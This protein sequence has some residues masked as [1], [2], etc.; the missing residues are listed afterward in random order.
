MAPP[1][2]TY[3]IYDTYTNTFVNT[4]AL[5]GVSF[6]NKING[7]GS[8]SASLS[9]S[10]PVYT[11]GEI[12]W[13]GSTEPNGNRSLF[14]DRDGVLVWA[15]TIFGRDYDS[16]SQSLSLSG[17]TFDWYKDT[18]IQKKPLNYASQDT[19]TLAR[20]VWFRLEDRANPI[21]FTYLT[22]L[23]GVDSA[24]TSAD[25]QWWV[26]TGSHIDLLTSRDPGGIEY[27]IDTY[28]DNSVSPQVPRKLFY[29]DYLKINPVDLGLTA[30]LNSAG[31]N[32]MSYNRS[33]D[34][35]K[36]CTDLYALGAGSDSAQA[37]GYAADASRLALG[38]PG[39]TITYSAGETSSPSSLDSIA[40]KQ[41]K[42]NNTQL[43]VISMTVKPDASFNVADIKP[44][45]KVTVQITDPRHP[46]GYS[47]TF[48]IAEYTVTPGDNGEESVAL[49][50]EQLYAG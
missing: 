40:K 2:Y 20:A 49:T 33:E 37:W 11:S 24:I 50:L 1:V 14:I 19:L 46:S 27:Y 35:T 23:A 38:Y 5:S 42:I 3:Y 22:N 17:P 32:I 7:G 34:G 25:N 45:R 28:W 29:A 21:T 47:N 39:V 36:F 13:L 15:G 48:R 26:P 18:K 41:L 12:D 4:L 31:G 9:I 10:D 8:F 16:E 6:S 30:S 44:G 43:D